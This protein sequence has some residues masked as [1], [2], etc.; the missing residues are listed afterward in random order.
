MTRP[1]LA[2]LIDLPGVDALELKALMKPAYAEPEARRD[3]PEIDACSLALFGLTAA[4]AE[5][6]PRGADWDGIELRPIAEQVEAFEAAGWD[7][8]DKKRRPLRVFGHFN[9]Q[10]WL[11]IRQVAGRLPFQ[12]H[13]DQPS[14]WA[15]GLAG[16]A[17]TF[18]R[19]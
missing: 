5:A 16:D 10:L 8:T 6:A 19:R 17:K 3:H 15:K 13:D 1:P 11:A 2:R 4:E 7:V 12:P 14:D 9:Q 18:R